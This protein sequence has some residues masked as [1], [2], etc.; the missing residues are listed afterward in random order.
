M[1]PRR[2]GI[3]LTQSSSQNI[4]W[5]LNEMPPPLLINSPNH[6]QRSHTKRATP[7]PRALTSVRTGIVPLSGVSTRL[8]LTEMCADADMSAPPATSTTTGRTNVQPRL[9]HPIDSLGVV[10]THSHI[11][12]P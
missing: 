8:D 10:P 5:V 11:L 9:S 1:H 3:P 6:H 12:H 2:H 7:L 4:S